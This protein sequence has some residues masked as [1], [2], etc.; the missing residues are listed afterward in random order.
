[1]AVKDANFYKYLEAAFRYRLFNP[2]GKLS[3]ANTIFSYL[4]YILPFK[5]IFYYARQVLPSFYRNTAEFPDTEEGNLK[6][7]RVVLEKLDKHKD[8]PLEYQ[9]KGTLTP[10]QER[11]IFDQIEVESRQNEGGGQT[12]PTDTTTSV[13]GLPSAP[14]MPTIRI[15][16]QTRPP[17]KLPTEEYV[18]PATAK[19]ER[20][21]AANTTSPRR[22]NFSAFRSKVGGKITNAAKIGLEKA[23]PFLGRAGN[24]LINNLSSIVNPGGMGG[25]GGGSRSIF[26]RFSRFGRGGGRA[27]SSAGKTVK[28]SRGLLALVGVLGFM[29]LVGGIAISGTSSTGEAV[30]I[31]PPGGNMGIGNTAPVSQNPILGNNTV[32]CPLPG[33]R[34]IGCG[35]FTSDSKYNR[36]VCDGPQPIDRGHCGKTYDPKNELCFKGT[37]EATKTQRWANS[38]DIDAPAG[39]KVIFPNIDSQAVSWFY[40]PGSTYNV[41]ESVGGGWGHAFTA[42]VGTD[43][44]TMYTVHMDKA[45]IPPPSGRDFYK[46]GD[47]VVT[48]ANTSYTHLHLN[49]GK[50][51]VNNVSDPGWL[52]PERLG[53]CT[54]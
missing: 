42:K 26:G 15:S 24:K 4:G 25:V 46:S 30:P 2:V 43:N 3:K 22:F 44:W 35:S 40:V 48:V 17:V 12:V 18:G 34:V 53:A 19:A 39:E 45:L 38:I 27:V 37:I 36:G 32:S 8:I 29:I 14:A 41:A 20:L 47:P 5:R 13:A 51:I 10:E 23:N 1:M 54:N 7:A 28:K 16:P 49:L 52:P 21:T 6:L 50:N 31:T 11:L 33:R 9:F